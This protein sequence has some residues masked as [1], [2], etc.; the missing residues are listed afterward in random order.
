MI[1]I[2]IASL[3]IR[4]HILY[5]SRQCR[6]YG[7]GGTLEDRLCLPRFGLLKVLF[8]EYHVTA[9]QQ[10]MMQKGTIKFKHNFSWTFFCFFLRN[11]WQPTTVH[12]SDAII[13][14]INMPLQMCRGRK[15]LH[16]CYRYF[17]TG[18]DTKQHVKIFFQRPAVLIFRAHSRF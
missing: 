17:V 5:T 12:K 8:L 1:L 10:T 6:R 14:L 9:S 11:Y 7:E 2:T 3:I 4:A 16:N 18:Y 15:V 13:R